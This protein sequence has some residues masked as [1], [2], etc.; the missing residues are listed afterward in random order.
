MSDYGGNNYNFHFLAGF[1]ILTSQNKCITVLVVLMAAC[2]CPSL[3]EIFALCTWQ[4]SSG[5]ILGIW[6]CCWAPYTILMAKIPVSV[7]NT[8]NYLCTMISLVE[9]NDLPHWLLD[10]MPAALSAQ[11][12]I[13]W[14]FLMHSCCGEVNTF[15]VVPW[16]EFVSVLCWLLSQD[17][18]LWGSSRH[19]LLQGS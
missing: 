12:R 3:V 9:R 18:D 2:S 15:P 6:K 7:A 13:Y 19:K 5:C 14:S 8:S 4:Q 10:M 17:I 11:V 16:G 1:D